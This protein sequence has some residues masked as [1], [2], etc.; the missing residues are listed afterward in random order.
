MRFL[1]WLKQECCAWTLAQ[2]PITQ[3]LLISSPNY[4][5]LNPVHPL[6]PHSNT[7]T[8]NE[9]FPDHYCYLEAPS[10]SS[11][12]P[13]PVPFT[14][15][16]SFYFPRLHFFARLSSF[17]GIK[18]HLSIYVIQDRVG[19]FNMTCQAFKTHRVFPGG[20]GIETSCFHCHRPGFS[21]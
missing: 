11:L 15:H 21:P 18:T 4:F 6:K 8:L 14:W 12:G 3:P 1:L 17:S 20:P 5:C 16:S 2:F 13:L 7:T 9:A 19:L 10:I